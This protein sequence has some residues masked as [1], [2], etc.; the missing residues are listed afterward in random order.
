[1]F[2]IL[3]A[4]RPVLLGLLLA[5]SAGALQIAHA[6]ERYREHEYREHEF[7]ER[8]YLDARYHHDHYY[9][10][11]GFVFGVL[12]PRHYVVFHGGIQFYFADGIWY[13]SDGRAR[14]VVVA[15]PFGVIVPVLPPSYATVWVGGVPYYYANDTYYEQSPGGY[16]VVAPPPS[17]VIVEQPP[18]NVI[19]QPAPNVMAQP[20]PNVVPQPTPTPVVPQPSPATVAQGPDQ[21]FI[22]P[23]NGQG[24]Q[25]QATDRYECHRWAVSQTGFDPTLSAGASPQKHADYQRALGACLEGRG[26][27]VK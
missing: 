20:A 21:V 24:E 8:Q 10:P 19:V 9:P 13:R 6:D 12:P 22:Y 25:R 4:R 26:Y 27:T 15:P 17:N 1:M 18:A 7:H 23:K 11:R 14:F 16:T 3:K 2:D 5:F